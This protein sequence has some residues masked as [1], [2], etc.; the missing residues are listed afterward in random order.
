M[1]RLIKIELFHFIYVT[2]KFYSLKWQ[3]QVGRTKIKLVGP[4]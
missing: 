1:V 3:F 2:I 4:H